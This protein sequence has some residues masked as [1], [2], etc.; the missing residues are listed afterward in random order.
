MGVVVP[1]RA[2]TGDGAEP[3]DADLV[4]A[5]REGDR[6]AQ[7]AL[8]R[9]HAR[10]VLGLAH[11][12]LARDDE[13]DDVVQDAFVAA[14]SGLRKLSDPQSFAKWLGS[15]TVRTARSRIRRRQ[16]RRRLGLVRGEPVDADRMVSPEAPPDVAAELRALYGMLERLEPDVRI[17]LVLRRVEGMTLPEIAEHMGLSLAT[18]KRKIQAGDVL[19]EGATRRGRA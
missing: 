18:V 2:P 13:V 7:D 17:A 11:R 8:Y 12:V 1:L 9:R 19:L 6:V 15:I 3:S 4:R 16:I 10:M 14:F 5:A